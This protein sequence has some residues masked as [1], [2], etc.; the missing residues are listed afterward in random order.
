MNQAK[1]KKTISN[2]DEILL[3]RH[4]DKVMRGTLTSNAIMTYVFN[5]HPEAIE[6]IARI[7]IGDD[8]LKIEK[9]HAQ[10]VAANLYGKSAIFDV[11]AT[12]SSGETINIEIQNAKEGAIPERYRWYQSILDSMSLQKGCDY[13]QLPTTY[14]IFLCEKYDDGDGE[15]ISHFDIVNRKT[16]RIMN[17]RMNYVIIDTS[18]R[19]DTTKVGRLCADM[20][21]SDPNK[22]HYEALAK[23]MKQ[24]KYTEEGV[25]NMCKRYD[26]TFLEGFTNGEKQGINQQV[27]KTVLKLVTRGNTD[28]NEMVD[29]TDSTIEVVQ[30]I[31]NKHNIVL[32][33]TPPS[34]SIDKNQPN[35]A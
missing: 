21:Q 33:Q 25:L 7:A 35:E 8:N 22:M 26:E 15:P 9:T 19:D 11:L 4:R 18:V 14:I 28:I 13:S 5:K 34:E 12:T 17:T 31:L 29:L 20:R 6:L 3:Q 24:I 2:I 27:E 10:D 30:E 32:P 23:P 1:P 16:K